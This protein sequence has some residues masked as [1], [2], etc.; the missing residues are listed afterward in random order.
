MPADRKLSDDDVAELRAMAA[1]G[2]SHDEL[3]A[4]FGISR[5]HVGR[6]VR[7]EQ[8]PALAAD[9]EPANVAAAVAAFLDDVELDAD[10]RVLAAT[11]RAVAA[12]LDACHASTSAAAAAATPRLAEALMRA[13][14]ALREGVPREPDVVDRLRARRADRLRRRAQSLHESNGTEERTNDGPP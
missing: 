4:Q 14:D 9:A 8:R 5:E 10:G 1:A 2:Q 12:K 7:G 3:S 6:L 13:L 11:A